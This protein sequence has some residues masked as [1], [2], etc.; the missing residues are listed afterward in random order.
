[1]AIGP[2]LVAK[3]TVRVFGPRGAHYWDVIGQ[4]IAAGMLAS[5]RKGKLFWSSL[6]VY[7]FSLGVSSGFRAMQMHIA[8]TILPDVGRGELTG[9]FSSIASISNMLSP[10]LY[11]FA[12]GVFTSESAPF[13]F[14]GVPFA[15]ASS[16]SLAYLFLVHT[17]SS[18]L[19]PWNKD[20]LRKV[21]SSNEM[22]KIASNNALKKHAGSAKGNK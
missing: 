17:I 6:G 18:E 3:H 1:M 14:P 4:I 22:R 15:I 19:W 5:S 13:Y 16:S 10:Q 9:R 2:R 11:A 7:L 20:A 12:F 21:A 8:T